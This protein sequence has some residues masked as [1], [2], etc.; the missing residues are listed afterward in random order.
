MKS[1]VLKGIALAALT[2]GVSQAAS[3]ATTLTNT[4]TNIVTVAAG[5]DIAA[6]GIDFGIITAIPAGGTT[7]TNTP[8]TT[9][10]VLVTGNNASGHPNQ[11]Y[12]GGATATS[13]TSPAVTASG[14]DT[15]SLTTP[16]GAV[17]GVL[18]TVIAAVP[19][20]SAGVYV[21]CTATPSSLTLTSSVAGSTTVAKVL[22]LATGAS[23]TAT[24]SKLAG[25]GGG[26]IATDIIDYDLTFAGVVANQAVPVVGISVFSGTYLA[27]GK[28]TAPASPKQG[29]YTDVVTATLN[30]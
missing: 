28:L 9:A 16:V 26:A 30:F 11:A 23:S 25:V 12:D 24:S 13:D 8:N 22:P 17:N 7:T 20:A 4:M 18:N 1:N 14:N 6:V 19:L 21:V 29:Y 10:G 5:C 3:A 27:T 15:L 2:F